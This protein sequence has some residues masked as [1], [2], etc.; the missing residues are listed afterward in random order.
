MA[1]AKSINLRG[2]AERHSD[3]IDLVPQAGDV[4]LVR[5]GALRS[6]A[7]RCPDG[8]GEVISVNLDPRTGP[9][10]KLYEREDSLTL[11]PSVWRESGCEAH[12][13]LWR[14]R[15]IWCDVSHPHSYRSEELK[16]RIHKLLPAP[17]LPHA[18]YADLAS[19][20][21]VIPWEALWTCESLVT[22]R[23]AVSSEKG[24]RFGL[25][26]ASDAPR[27]SNVDRTA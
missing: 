7:I 16:R 19:Q 10:W 26:S 2:T 23:L 5:R 25:A 11:F 22:D 4:A 18:H 17:G 24:S 1:R 21:D 9:A 15:L 20:L 6:L 8:C 13:I 14:N 27:L 3:A 12:F